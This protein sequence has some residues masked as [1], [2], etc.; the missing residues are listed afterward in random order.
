MLQNCIESCKMGRVRR[1]GP[2]VRGRETEEVGQMLSP[3]RGRGFYD[4]QSEV[5][6][7]F[8]EMFGNMPRRAGGQQR[9]AAEWA[10]AVDVI[11]RDGNLVVRAEIPG[12][13]PEDV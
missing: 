2:G 8:D 1:T 9:Q 12:V 10:P 13:K 3:F 11:N 6:R 7:V 4:V 5:N